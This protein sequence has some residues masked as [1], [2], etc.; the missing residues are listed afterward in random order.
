MIK[1]EV[2]VSGQ[3]SSNLA[4]GSFI[5]KE[6]NFHRSCVLRIIR[7]LNSFKNNPLYGRIILMAAV[8]SRC[9]SSGVHPIED[10]RH[11]KEG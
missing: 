4:Q 2:S 5:F 11:E 8:M 7:K 6:L 9:Y 10:H 1:C 3:N